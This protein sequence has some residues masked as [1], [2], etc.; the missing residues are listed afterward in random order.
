MLLTQESASV[1]TNAFFFFMGNPADYR[2]FSKVIRTLGREI[3]VIC[4]IRP[5]L[6]VQEKK[7]CKTKSHADDFADTDGFVI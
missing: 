5:G 6:S 1:L 3:S 4:V 7:T 2:A